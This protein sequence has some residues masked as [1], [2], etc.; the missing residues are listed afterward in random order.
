M[1][2]NKA[3]WRTGIDN[4]IVSVFRGFYPVHISDQFLWVH[5]EIARLIFWTGWCWIPLTQT[6][7]AQP[8]P[9]LHLIKFD[10]AEGWTVREYASTSVSAWKGKFNL[11]NSI[12]I[13]AAGHKF[14][15]GNEIQRRYIFVQK[16]DQ[17]SQTALFQMYKALFTKSLWNDLI[18]IHCEDVKSI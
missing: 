9:R 17:L 6:V 12:E 14:E 8:W 3:S 18:D 5:T 11:E 16:Y 15:W 10:Q 7:G 2:C 1:F 13:E 4:Q